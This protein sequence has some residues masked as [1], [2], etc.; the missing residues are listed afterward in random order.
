MFDITFTLY[1]QVNLLMHDRNIFGYSSE[2][3]ASLCVSLEISGNLRKFSKNVRKRFCGLR[4]T[5]GESS[6]IPTP[7]R[8][9]F[10]VL[11][12]KQDCRFRN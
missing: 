2:V 11:V 6:E 5:I 7:Y 4:T 10:N 1:L 9:L 8:S 3:F 12:N